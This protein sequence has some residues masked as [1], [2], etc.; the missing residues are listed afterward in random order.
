MS[1][2]DELANNITDDAINFQYESQIHDE[3]LLEY[4]ETFLNNLSESEYNLFLNRF[5]YKKSYKELSV[6]FDTTESNIRKKVFRLKQKARSFAKN[7][8]K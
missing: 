6:I 8:I 7:V 1:L 5:V 2:T 3:Q 4:K